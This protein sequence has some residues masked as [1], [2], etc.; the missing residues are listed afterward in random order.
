MKRIWTHE[1]TKGKWTASY[2]VIHFA[3]SQLKERVF[4]LTSENGRMKSFE[5]WQAAKKMGW[6]TN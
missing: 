2:E 3:G 1:K 6:K 4:M 5:S